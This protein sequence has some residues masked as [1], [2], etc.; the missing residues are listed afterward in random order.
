M[1]R[2]PLSLPFALAATLA[3]FCAALI[4]QIGAHVALQLGSWLTAWD[5]RVPELNGVPL[6]AEQTAMMAG[7][8]LLSGWVRRLFR[9]PVLAEPPLCVALLLVL[10]ALFRGPAGF[11]LGSW[12]LMLVP[13]GLAW[14]IWRTPE[15]SRGPRRALANIRHR[16]AAGGWTA[17]NVAAAI[18]SNLAPSWIVARLAHR[19]GG[20]AAAL[21]EAVALA[22]ANRFSDLIAG[23]DLAAE[24]GP[25]GVDYLR[26]QGGSLIAA[27]RLAFLAQTATQSEI[28]EAV[29]RGDLR[30]DS[31]NAT[32]SAGE[33]VWEW[34]REAGTWRLAGVCATPPPQ[35]AGGEATAARGWAFAGAN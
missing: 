34:R 32:I 1:K 18:A 7:A 2:L 10:A 6:A 26:G 27:D 9:A 30:A 29:R 17:P 35:N 8:I 3:A 13:L 31:V 19:P 24:R 20:V 11:A 28:A 4:F 21:D 23:S 5:L 22:Q 14:W 15:L 25:G 33:L 16:I 12:A